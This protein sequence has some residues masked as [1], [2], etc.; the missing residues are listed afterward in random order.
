MLSCR[1]YI[2]ENIYNSY[3]EETPDCTYDSKPDI[4]LAGP[5][6]PRLL[7]FTSLEGSVCH[8][9]KPPVSHTAGKVL[10]EPFF[11]N[12]V[13]INCITVKLS[14]LSLQKSFP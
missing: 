6:I 4:E 5:K 7:M 9:V 8:R 12:I 1:K 3:T 13:T 10:R 2:S 14:T 11:F